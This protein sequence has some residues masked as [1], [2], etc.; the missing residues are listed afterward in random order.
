MKGCVKRRDAPYG[1][2]T[3]QSG[4]RPES[5]VSLTFEMKR[6]YDENHSFVVVAVL[7]VVTFRATEVVLVHIPSNVLTL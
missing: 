5:Q 1:L 7:V 6:S 2:R 4:V 3:L